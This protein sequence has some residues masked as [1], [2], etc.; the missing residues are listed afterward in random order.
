VKIR[1]LIGFWLIAMLGLAMCGSGLPDIGL[2]SNRG[3][4][5][6]GLK[7]ALNRSGGGAPADTIRIV[8]RDRLFPNTAA[9]AAGYVTAADTV[10]AIIN[11]GSAGQAVRWGHVNKG[12]PTTVYYDASSPYQNYYISCAIARPEDDTAWQATAALGFIW[13]SA[14]GLTNGDK[15]ES[16]YLMFNVAAFESF[17]VAADCYVA[18]R[19][20]TNSADYAMVASS[21]VGY[22]ADTDTARMDIS[23]DEVDAT[24][25]TAWV[26][27]L[28]D[29]TDRHDFGPRSDTVIGPGT[30][31]AAT[32][33]RLNV[34]DAVQQVSDNGTLGRGMLFVIYGAPFAQTDIA[35]FAA[36]D[37]GPYVGAGQAK[38]C[39][40][41]I[42]TA[43]SR[44]GPRE[45]GGVARAPLVFTFD[46]Q[47]PVQSGYFSAL[48]ALGKTFDVAVYRNAVNVFTWV[49]S[50]YTLKPDPFYLI[51]HSYRHP[52]VGGLT[53]AALDSQLTR[54]WM[55]VEFTGF[56]AADTLGVVDW[57]W[58]GGGAAPVKSLAAASRCVDFGYRSARG[59]NA[60]WLL[61]QPGFEYETYLGWGNWA[62]PYAIKATG[63]PA[64]FGVGA[65]NSE[66]QLAEEL[67][68]LID[69]HYT[70]YGKAPIIIYGHKY[71]AA[72]ADY[73]S[74][75]ALTYLTNLAATL[76]STEV[77]SYSDVLSLRLNGA[78]HKTPA[79]VV[80]G[81]G[82]SADSNAIQTFAAHMD[83]A[84][85]AD[86]DANYLQMWIGPK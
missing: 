81:R 36:G 34:T 79:Q 58:P 6:I 13:V 46:D 74:P 18:A 52:S 12:A 41:F 84:Y 51:H 57:A 82:V 78:V 29:R 22:G 59:F 43:T 37:Y 71:D 48:E 77:M 70:D 39:P 2:S 19:L 67:G 86:S 26:P 1:A 20:D 21:I 47:Y 53:G 25:N 16:A 56:T 44:R 32:C 10:G 63:A 28:D 11:Q 30:Y 24:A 68:D 80:A 50:L 42:A 33:L 65:A 75:A 3:R 54:A 64:L 72:P 60:G 61:G 23:W 14:N 4:M 73:I 49:D 7:T 5:D 8:S 9:R 85:T 69:L 40:T 76:N 31:A 45:W 83:S 38:G 35:L 66:A 17:I 55:P 15:I 27:D 62:N